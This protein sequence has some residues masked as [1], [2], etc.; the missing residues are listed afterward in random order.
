MI[1]KRRKVCWYKFK[2]SVGLEDGT[3][4]QFV[5]R[6]SARTGNKRDAKDVEDE[7]R[8]ALRLGEIH[9]LDPWPKPPAPEAPVFREFSK[10]FLEYAELH[11][12]PGTHRFYEECLDRVLLF[13]PLAD[14]RLSDVTGEL[15]AKYARWRRGQAAGNSL[16]TVNAEL[17]TLRRLLRL[18]EE[19]AVIGKAP[20]VHEL[21]GQ[22]GRDRVLTFEEEAKYLSKASPTLRDAAVLAVDTGLRPESELFELEWIS[23]HLESS[24]DAPHGYVHVRGSKSEAGVRNVPLTS[25]GHDV[26]E[27]RKAVSGKNRFVFPGSGRSGHLQSLQHP[28][29]RAMDKAGLEHFVLYS[30]RHT[31][32]TRCAESGMDKFTLARLMGHS[33]FRVTERYYVHVTE[34]HVTAGFERFL[35]YHTN[36]IVDSI[37]AQTDSVQ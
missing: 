6:R 5:I 29:E 3:K 17:R 19:W 2:W 37:P 7:H 14:A 10:R 25:R 8:R 11:T 12:K 24:A 31:F 1:Y 30:F 28:H 16:A 18:A 33:S 27:T 15:I 21:P 26:L 13:T 34:P 23:V 22:R 36:K 9:P 32:G 20:A 35:V 4:Q